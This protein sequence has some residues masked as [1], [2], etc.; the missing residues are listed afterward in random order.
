ME[1]REQ[2]GPSGGPMVGTTEVMS[3]AKR[4]ER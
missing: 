4:R 2:L 1:L 3:E